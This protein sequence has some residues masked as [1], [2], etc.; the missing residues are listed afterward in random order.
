[1]TNKQIKLTYFTPTYNR[2]KLLPNL[3]D[4]LLRQ[5]DK[6]FIWLI[7]DDGSKDGTEA[8]VSLWQKE[9]KIQI[10]YIKKE[11]GGKHTAIDLSNEVCKTEFITCIDS[12]DYLTDDA[13]EILYSKF[14]LC[15][16]DDCCGL[17]GPKLILNSPKNNVWTSTN[18]KVYF[19]DL[20]KKLG[21][22]PETTIVL[23]TEIAKK[24]HFPVFEDE[25]F[26]TES[27]YYQNF[28]YDYKFVT[29]DNAIYIAEYQP[30]GYTQMGMKLFLKN[31]KGYAYALKQ[32]AYIAIKKRKSFKNKLKKVAIFYGW[33]GLLKIKANF[34]SDYK[35][36]WFYRFVGNITKPIT[37]MMMK[38]RVYSNEN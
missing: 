35:L 26:V 28:F 4:S 23:K 2:E 10:E 11:N 22:I 20:D 32:N 3:Y 5:T 1:M 30:D 13:T 7:I 33:L 27:V 31:P 8:L 25:R 12:D 36:P 38:R 15:L 14:D 21:F 24:F 37:K 6:N 9:N 17:L 19:Y 16:D 34:T 18:E 29:F